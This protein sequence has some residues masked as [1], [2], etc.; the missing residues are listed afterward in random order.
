MLENIDINVKTIL[1]FGRK[2]TSKSLCNI[3]N[4]HPNVVY[5][6]EYEN[7]NDTSKTRV[8][9]NVHTFTKNIMISSFLC[10]IKPATNITVAIQMNSLY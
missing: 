3:I 9:S 7:F 5:I 10:H 1:R 4:K 2:P 6:D 8:K